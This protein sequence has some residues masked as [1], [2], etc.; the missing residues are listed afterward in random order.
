V[1][2]TIYL[3]IAISLNSCCKGYPYIGNVKLL[4]QS[5]DSIRQ[6]SIYYYENDINFSTPKDSNNNV[7]SFQNKND[8]DFMFSSK[9]EKYAKQFKYV[10]F[11]R[12]KKEEY[13]IK[14]IED[15]GTASNSCGS[16]EHYLKIIEIN[17]TRRV[18][19]NNT[20]TLN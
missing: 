6:T 20:I 5:K 11:Y 16:G 9:N 12:T 15:Y 17:G 8:V 7:S 3:L 10:I 1:K 14:V 13:K 18:N 2:Y 4:N 19:N